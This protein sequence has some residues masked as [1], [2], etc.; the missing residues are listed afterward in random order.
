[1]AKQNRQTTKAK[2]GR[3]RTRNYVKEE[4]RKDSSQKRVN[5]DNERESKF[6]KQMRVDAGMKDCRSNDIMWYAKNPELLRSAASI[7]FSTTVGLKPE[8]KIPNAVPGVLQIDWTPT[9][10]G[11]EAQPINQAAN[12]IY[13]FTV[14]ANSRNYSYNPPDQMKLILAG[15]QVFSALA[16]GIRAYGTMLNY[17]QRDYYTPSALINAM[18]F[19]YVDWRNNLSTAWFTLNELISRASQIWIPTTMPVLNRWFW[20]N[21]NVYRDGESAKS[22]YYVF[23]QR[24]YYQYVVGTTQESTKLTYVNWAEGMTFAQY[25]SS[26]NALITPLLESEDRGII[27]GDILKA[28]GMENIFAMNPITADYRV[29]PTYDREVLTQIENS[30]AIFIRPDSISED[31]SSGR[32][33]E[34]WTKQTSINASIVAPELQILNFHQIEAPTPEQVMIA[35]RLKCAGTIAL[36]YTGTPNASYTLSPEVYGTEIITQYKSIYYTWNPTPTLMK[37]AWNSNFTSTNEP[38]ATAVYQWA[39]FDW[40]PWLYGITVPDAPTSANVPLIIPTTVALGDYDNYTYI[41]KNEL[42]KMHTTALYSEFG[43]PAI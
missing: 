39:A 43:V 28:Y 27:F 26:V 23:R 18:G 42:A 10:G 16:A 6:A 38:G 33:I 9:V 24:G 2:G 20:L 7:P 40:A 30:N 12:S 17:D 34:T 32:L 5:F 41:S 21:S 13:S 31:A 35:T 29:T 22:Q 37:L 8:F 36:T 14:H 4:P 25:V 1:M 15:M 3:Q 19:D 11:M